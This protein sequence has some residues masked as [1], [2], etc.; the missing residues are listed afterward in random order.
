M[1]RIYYDSGYK[2]KCAQSV[3]FIETKTNLEAIYRYTVFYNWITCRLHVDFSDLLW[4]RDAEQWTA[5][6]KQAAASKTSRN[7]ASAA[8][9]LK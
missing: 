1:S 7:M 2:Y 5:T 3:F 8:E 6:R 9:N 4:V